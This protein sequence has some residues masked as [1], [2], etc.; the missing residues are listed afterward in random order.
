[1]ITYVL[2]GIAFMFCV[3]FL[4]NT[5]NYKLTQEKFNPDL[6]DIEMNFW[7]RILGVIFWPICLV[8]FIYNFFKQLYK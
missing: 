3:E 6:P 7:V 1:M 4:T 2:I 5:H 8:I